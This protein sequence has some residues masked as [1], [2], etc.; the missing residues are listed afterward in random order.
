MKDKK[1]REEWAINKVQLAQVQSTEANSQNQTTTTT[2]SETATPIR[3]GWAGTHC[4]FLQK[5]NLKD[6]ILLDSDSTETI[7]CNPKYVNNIHTTNETLE[8]G[9]NGG[10]MISSMKCEV[11][12]LGIHWFNENS[13]T[14]IIS[15]AHMAAKYKVTYDSGKEKA[16]LVH[17]PNKIVKFRQFSNGLYGMH[18]E[19]PN[20]YVEKKKGMQM[21]NSIEE[22]A[23]YLS[24]R[25]L[26]KAHKAR[27]LYYALGTPSVDDLKAMIRMNLIRNN[28]VTTEDVKLAIKAF[29]P[30]VAGIKGKTTRRKPIP[31]IDNKIEIPE[32]LLEVQRDVVLSI[33]GMTVNTLKFLTTISHDIQYRT[34][35]Y[36]LNTTAEVFKTNLREVI[37]TYKKGG[38]VVKEIHCDNEFRPALDTL[39]LEYDPPLV[40]NYATADE[41]VPRAE[42]NNRVIKERVR[43]TYHRLPYTTL[44]RTMVKYMVLESARK[45]NFFPS[46]N[47][48][49][50]YYSPRMIL[51]QENLDFA[52]HCQFTFGEYVQ[53]HDEPNPTNTNAPRSLDCIY[54]RP[55]GNRQGGHELLH[56]QTNR[57]I[58]RRR[59]TP[60][61]ITPFIIQQVNLLADADG[62]PPGLKVA[63]RVNNILFDSAWTAGVEY[64]LYEIPE[65]ENNQ[66][67]DT[68]D[69]ADDYVQDVMD[70]NE[71]ADVLENYPN[72]ERQPEIPQAQDQDQGQEFPVIENNDSDNDNE[73]ND[74]ESDD[75]DYSNDELEDTNPEEVSDEEIIEDTSPQLRRSN[76]APV[77]NRR[78]ANT[79]V[80]RNKHQYNETTANHIAMIMCQIGD[81]AHYMSDN[82]A[83]NFAQTYSLKSGLKKFGERGEKAAFKEMKQLHDRNVWLPIKLSKL[84]DKERKRAMESLI[85][86]SEKRDGTVKARTCANGSTQRPYTPKEEAASPTAATE[87]IMI[88]GVIEAKQRRDVMTL[89]VPNAFVQT[90]IPQMSEKIIMK[91]RGPLVDI[92][93]NINPEMY[94]D[95]VVMEGKHKVLYVQMLK[96]LYGMM[97][98]SILY[99]KKFRTDIEK[100]GF[101]VNP[102][103][104]CVA[105]RMVNGKQHTITWHVDDVKSSHVDPKVN[106]EFHEWCE[107]MYGSDET[108]HVKVVRGKTHDYL[109]MVLDYSQEDKLRIDMRYYVKDMLEKFPEDVEAIKKAP[110]S[111][112]L[113]KVDEKSNILEDSRK[114]IFHTFVMKAM[115][116]C[117]RG[118]PDIGI[119]IC[120]LASRV[121]KPNENDWNKLVRV[122]GFLKATIDELLTLE[123]DDSQN[124]YWFI[125]AAFA[126]HSDMRS[127]TGAMLTLGKGA[128]LSDSTKQKAN[129]RSSTEAELNAIDD[130]ISK[131]LWVKKFVE[132]QGF[133]IMLN[134]IYQDNTSTIKLSNNGSASSGKRTRHFD[135]KLFYVTDLIDK[136]EVEIEYCATGDMI[137]DYMTKPL[138]G[139]Q[140]VR[141]RDLIMN[142]SGKSLP[143]AQQECVGK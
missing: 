94:K 88:T 55:T 46:K 15:L 80:T 13:M 50:K 9:T 63:N 51:H 5:A 103:D 140:F 42:R 84:T 105:N 25:Q 26:V 56:L 91:I 122:L 135:I 92:L 60:V 45:L 7:F 110:W 47:G 39:S 96:A 137:A 22:N 130:K 128:V 89:D 43:T 72:Y 70:E 4:N 138:T 119:A 101:V 125:D 123:A 79:H 71:I 111:D 136:D 102:Y 133:D 114:A 29:G 52:K 19:D 2:S 44:P 78:Y 143:V 117:K 40:V 37:G 106:D 104:I 1:P 35:Q 18:P 59:C 61:P 54:L 86:L 30:D 20:S 141:F 129:A 41:H 65:E 3:R 49:S 48:V 62:M 131:V 36:L 12:H 127:H 27:Q 64:E 81:I 53:A 87:A 112:K 6:L 116:L 69:E 124:L 93:V 126:V 58:T 10:P 132:A 121:T 83:F 21:V 142:L 68:E 120:F 97:I 31:V 109:A 115:F 38:F 8:L 74:V 28:E 14:N 57:V 107:K 34:A 24:P 73:D 100:I 32:E 98:A 90:D 75:E 11:P 77:P 113:F 99:Y 76:R 85:F 95:Y 134:I 82:E 139:K 67:D 118:R 16:F 17:M 23:T 108:G 66:D 33:D